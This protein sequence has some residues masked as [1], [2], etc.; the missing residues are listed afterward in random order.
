MTARPA[1]ASSTAARRSSARRGWRRV[2]VRSMSVC[3]PTGQDAPGG[4]TTAV[5]PPLRS[6]TDQLPKLPEV[7]DGVVPVLPPLAITGTVKVAP[8]QAS[9]ALF[10][11]AT[12]LCRV[13]V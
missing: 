5:L 7:A 3:F 9:S 8:W 4:R 12:E 10:D 1:I 6:A 2:V 13:S 11:M